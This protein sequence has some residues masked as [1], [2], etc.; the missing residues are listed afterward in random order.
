MTKEVFGMRKSIG[1][2]Q[3]MALLIFV[4][5]IQGIGNLIIKKLTH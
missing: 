1:K 2:A 4:N 5:V 3:G